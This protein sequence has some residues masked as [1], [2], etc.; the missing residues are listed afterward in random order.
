MRQEVLTGMVRAIPPPPPPID[1]STEIHQNQDMAL[2][3]T[4]DSSQATHMRLYGSNQQQYMLQALTLR[5]SA[6]RF[7][8]SEFF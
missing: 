8:T 5:D 2:G 3:L 4:N 1:L 6:T 7:S